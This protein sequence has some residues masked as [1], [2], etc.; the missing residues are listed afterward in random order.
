MAIVSNTTGQLVVDTRA[1]SGL[2]QGLVDKRTAFRETLES[3]HA[4][5]D[6]LEGVWVGDNHDRFWVYFEGRY[7]SV[8][9]R[10]DT[11]T[12]MYARILDAITRYN[13]LE[14]NLRMAASSD[15]FTEQQPRDASDAVG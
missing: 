10:Y 13:L 5:I 4:D 9:R 14:E 11:I 8:R 7:Q 1:M 2:A 12:T 3:I 15:A 6:E